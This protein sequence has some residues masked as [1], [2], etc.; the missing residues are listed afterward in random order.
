[1]EIANVVA[2]VTMDRKHPIASVTRAIEG[3]RYTHKSINAVLRLPHGTAQYSHNGRLLIVGSKSVDD[4]RKTIDA[5][6]HTL[7][8]HG[9]P[10][11]ALNDMK[12]CS[13]T[14]KARVPYR[15][16]LAQLSELLGANAFY[17]PMSKFSGLVY[18]PENKNFKNHVSVTIFTTGTWHVCGIKEPETEIPWIVAHME[19]F[20]VAAKL[21]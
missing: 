11:Q 13:M 8:K 3:I 15:L 7:N 5:F 4:V 10:T 6:V 18:K 19:P 17:N 20:L 14:A 9:F 2:V 21:L 12:V 16:C 1:M